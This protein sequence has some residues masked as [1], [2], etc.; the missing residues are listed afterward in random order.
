MPSRLTEADRDRIARARK[1]R[2]LRGPEAVREYT[3]HQDT[4]MAYVT[5]FSEAQE[6]LGDLAIR[7]LTL[8]GF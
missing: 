7:L 8:G 5:A 2:G 6:L 4:G 1:L 3:G